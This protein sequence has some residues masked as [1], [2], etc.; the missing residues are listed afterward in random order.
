MKTQKTGFIL[1]LTL[2]IT[3]IAV[4]LV[5]SLFNTN[6]VYIPFMRTMI[7]R[8][9]AKMIAHSGLQVAVAQLAQEPKQEEEKTEEKTGEEKEKEKKPAGNGQA[10]H[11]LTTILPTINRW[12]TFKLQEEVEGID[13]EIKICISCEE[14]KID[15]NEW[16]DFKKH[17][18]KSIQE[19]L[20]YQGPLEDIFKQMQERGVKA[21]LFPA[22][23]KFLQERSYE[24]DDITELLTIKEFIA[25]KQHVFYEPPSEKEE[26]RPL[27]LTDVFTV[28]SGKKGLQPWLFSDSIS[29]ILDLQRAQAG[30][31]EKRKQSLDKWLEN[32]K[33]KVSLPDD[34]E[35]VFEPLYGK[36][37]DSL[38]KGIEAFLS[39][40]FE[41]KTF[42]VLSYGKVGDVT[43]KLFAIIRRTVSS[44]KNG[45]HSIAVT[46]KKIYWI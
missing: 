21:E 7:D 33:Q 23:E 37:F 4:V 35:T 10:K 12:Q 32:F 11:L 20:S 6:M 46:I 9:K 26:K 38:P 42:S 22:F 16:Y 2:M 13:A 8:E 43:Q 41:P 19:G 44:K 31:V 29:S 18:F 24:L 30:D 3:S 15:L 34:W 36:D 28:W 5:T 45:E 17:E 27:Y 25:F 40:T 1:I 39:S 14:G